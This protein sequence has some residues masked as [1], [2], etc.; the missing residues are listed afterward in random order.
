[1]RE[2]QLVEESGHEAV[3]KY[4]D[5]CTGVAEKMYQEMDDDD[6]DDDDDGESSGD[7]TDA[8]DNGEEDEEDDAGDFG[9]ALFDDVGVRAEI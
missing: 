6:D 3:Q 4:I 7:D 8:Q 9:D 2:F 5:K 1:M